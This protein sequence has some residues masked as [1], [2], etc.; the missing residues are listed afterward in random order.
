[1]APLL[2]VGLFKLRHDVPPLTAPVPWTLA[3]LTSVHKFKSPPK[4]AP[5]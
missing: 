2:K 1:M 4:V 3:S 5:L